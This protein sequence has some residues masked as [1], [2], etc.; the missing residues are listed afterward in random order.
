MPGQEGLL[1]ISEIADHRIDKVEDVLKQGDTVEVMVLDVDDQGRIKLSKRVVDSKKEGKKTKGRE[2]AS[3]Q[4][5]Q[6]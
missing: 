4:G 2:P 6:K 5:K 3:Q 1:H